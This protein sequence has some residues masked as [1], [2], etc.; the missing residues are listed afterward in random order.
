MKKEFSKIELEVLC[1]ELSDRFISYE[2]TN[3]SVLGDKEQVREDLYN[4]FRKELIAKGNNGQ[5]KI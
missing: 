2:D 5:T 1:D 4:Q 3:D